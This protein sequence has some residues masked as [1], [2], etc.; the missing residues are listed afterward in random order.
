M[1]GAIIRRLVVCISLGFWI[2][3][4]CQIGSQEESR[5]A[6]PTQEIE[7]S[8]LQSR[9]NAASITNEPPAEVAEDT[10]QAPVIQSRQPIGIDNLFYLFQ[11]G[12]PMGDGCNELHIS[13]DGKT[14]A[15]YVKTSQ[16]A[17][18]VLYS[19]PD[20]NQIDELAG[21]ELEDLHRQRMVFSPDG[22]KLA[23]GQSSVYKQSIFEYDLVTKTVN[24]IEE[25]DIVIFGKGLTYAPDGNL[26]KIPVDVEAPGITGS[27]DK[28]RLVGYWEWSPDRQKLV[29]LFDQGRVYVWDVGDENQSGWLDTDQ[30]FEGLGVAFD[31]DTQE[32]IWARRAVFGT[33]VEVLDEQSGLIGTIQF[34]KDPVK[35]KWLL[36]GKVVAAIRNTSEVYFYRLDGQAIGVLLAGL[37]DN[38]QI[39]D[40]AIPPD[41]SRM[42]VCSKEGLL[43]FSVQNPDQ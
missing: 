20:G 21:I 39:L 27:I 31:E 10:P 30:D 19:L 4:G 35:I 34:G 25:V 12:D 18:I 16:D 36:G 28:E 38:N 40:L 2:L 26:L 33:D 29:M 42:Y 23:F 5:V 24:P 13:P 11:E 17:K 41:R 37:S 14:L 32:M 22:L 1:K 43:V 7:Q 6:S 8:S 9:E 3:A 15:T